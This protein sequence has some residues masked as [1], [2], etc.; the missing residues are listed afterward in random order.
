MC[1][2]GRQLLLPVLAS[3]FAI[4]LVLENAII[5]E[6]H[7]RPLTSLLT[8]IGLRSERQHSVTGDDLSIHSDADEE[9]ADLARPGKPRSYGCSGMGQLTGKDI[10]YADLQ[11]VDLRY[12][13]VSAT[14][15]TIFR[16]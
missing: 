16:P 1:T 12:F 4:A 11:V 13:Q 5:S 8:S 15:Q 14:W 9:Y 6:R 10:V 3:L 7:S 2:R